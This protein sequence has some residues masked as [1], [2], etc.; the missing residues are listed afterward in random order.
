MKKKNF[1]LVLIL[2][3]L[4]ILAGCKLFDKPS[5]LLGTWEIN[6]ITE[7]K[8][9]EQIDENTYPQG[10]D[11]NGYYFKEYLQFTE[12]RA[13]MFY[14]Q[15]NDEESTVYLLF[16]IRYTE[17]ADGK[18]LIID[19][20]EGSYSYTVSGKFITF[21]AIETDGEDVR[22]L[23]KEGKRVDDSKVADWIL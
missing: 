13:W 10:P 22:R 1:L 3:A 9:D 14:E 20:E 23:V 5:A 4:T 17:G 6:T 12:D 18:T 11:E 16:V 15:Y 7:Y 8:N 19:G 2:L 21:T